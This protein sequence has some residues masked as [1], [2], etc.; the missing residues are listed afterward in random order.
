MLFQYELLILRP[1]ISLFPL[2]YRL[3]Q[4][5][6]ISNPFDAISDISD[7]MLESIVQSL[8]SSTSTNSLA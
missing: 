3:F 8:I 4:F 5:F 2:T 6:I 7:T 1:N